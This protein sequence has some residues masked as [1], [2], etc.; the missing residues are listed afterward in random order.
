M[1]TITI[2]HPTDPSYDE[3]HGPARWTEPLTDAHYVWEKAGIDLRQFEGRA[4]G[5]C[6]RSVHE[7]INAILDNPDQFAGV[8]YWY[9]QAVTAHLTGLFFTLRRRPDGIV[10]VS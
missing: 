8:S 4:S 3:H 10:H 9:L 5:A 6:A 2:P 1:I 7:L